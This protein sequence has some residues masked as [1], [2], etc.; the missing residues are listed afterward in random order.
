MNL[1][2]KIG[3]LAG[4]ALVLSG[5]SSGILISDQACGE[6]VP[7]DQSPSLIVHS[8]QDGDVSGDTFRIETNLE[9]QVTG[10]P[11]GSSP[12]G[13]VVQSFPVNAVMKA[14]FGIEG[15]AEAFDENS[16]YFIPMEALPNTSLSP[17]ANGV[18]RTTHVIADDGT[19]NLWFPLDN[20]Y[21]S[22][23]FPSL[24]HAP[25]SVVATC[26]SNVDEDGFIAPG[27]V[28]FFDVNTFRS[29]PDSSSYDITPGYVESLIDFQNTP[30][31]M[32]FAS[33]ISDGRVPYIVSVAPWF[34]GFQQ[35][36]GFFG[37]G[38][39][40]GETLDYEEF[41]ISQYSMVDTTDDFIFMNNSQDP[42]FEFTFDTPFNR[43]AY[44]DSYLASANEGQDPENQTSREELSADLGDLEFLFVYAMYLD[45]LGGGDLEV[46]Y[47][48][49]K[50]YPGIEGDLVTLDVFEAQQETIASSPNPYVG[51]VITQVNPQEAVPG[52][53]VAI[54]GQKLDS[55]TSIKIDNLNA[56]IIEQSGDSIV[57]QLPEELTPGLKDIVAQSSFGRLISQSSLTV[58]AQKVSAT[59]SLS[60]QVKRIDANS[61]RIAIKNPVDAGKLQ[62]FVN[63]KEVAWVRAV[64][65]TDP[66]L[67]IANGIPYLVRTIN[68][69]SGKN[70]IEVY[71]DGE[72]IRRVSY[73]K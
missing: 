56:E 45:D 64:D 19:R 8:P 6:I 59:G 26:G 7:V 23:L 29:I 65:E 62:V 60:T 33:T 22:P 10:L 52:S 53:K 72:R 48:F 63:G 17:D 20:Y 18:F 40:P 16:K 27:P 55:I 66:K 31:S 73:K 41:W 14:I 15:Q 67:R 11:D 12:E 54:S 42:V 70:V 51:P 34:S 43:D 47:S 28:D 57:I 35:D 50:F 32:S 3:I 9:W 71:L 13:F 69:E 46:S 21:D 36:Y 44:L 25:M 5:C 38:I 58:S 61:A 1:V 37:L 49:E 39:D 68:L 4:S 30:E 24:F 2:S